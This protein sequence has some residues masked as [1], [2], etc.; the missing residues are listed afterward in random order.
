VN[1][2]CNSTP[3]EERYVA[4]SASASVEVF[5]DFHADVGEC[6]RVLRPAVISA[7]SC[8]VRERSDRIVVP[9][10][11]VLLRGVC[12][13]AIS[14]R[15]GACSGLRKCSHRQ[16]GRASLPCGLT[17]DYRIKTQITRHRVTTQIPP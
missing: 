12:R 14:E 8:S 13:L 5:A 11:G 3:N 2:P 4:R 16:V 15:G 1:D 17:A 10:A 6:L 7:A 9:P